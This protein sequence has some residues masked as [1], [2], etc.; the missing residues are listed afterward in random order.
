MGVIVGVNAGEWPSAI[1]HVSNGEPASEVVLRRPSIDL[2]NRTLALKTFTEN[3]ETGR[4]V[5]AGNV[6]DGSPGSS[7]LGGLID[8]FN[9]THTHAG[10]GIS[11][12]LDWQAGYDNDALTGP[13]EAAVTLDAGGSFSIQ[14]SDT[15]DLLKF[16]ETTQE[17]SA[18]VPVFTKSVFKFG[19][20]AGELNA[21]LIPNGTT[22]VLLDNTEVTSY[23]DH[24]TATMSNPH[25]HKYHGYPVN[26]TNVIVTGGSHIVTTEMSG[27]DPGGADGV[28]GIVT[29]PAHNNVI[30]RNVD[31]NDLLDGTGNKVYGRITESGGVWTLSFYSNVAGSEVAHNGFSSQEIQWW[32]QKI[33][34]PQDRPVYNPLFELPANQLAAVV[35]WE[36]VPTDIIPAGAYTLGESGN[37]WENFHLEKFKEVSF[38]TGTNI[39]NHLDGIAFTNA[40][41]RFESAFLPLPA[42][43]TNPVPFRPQIPQNIIVGSGPEAH[44]A[45]IE[46]AIANAVDGDTIYVTEDAFSTESM[47]WTSS[48]QRIRVV[49]LPGVIYEFNIAS[50][51]GYTSYININM[52]NATID[53]LT[54]HIS[55][56]RPNMLQAIFFNGSNSR[57]INARVRLLSSSN[58]DYGVTLANSTGGQH[59]RMIIRRTP[60]I[61]GSIASGSFRELNTSGFNS[62]VVQL[63]ET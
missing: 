26:K 38:G 7:V 45:T 41:Q 51:P 59:L 62:A 61:S 22:N 5:Q 10:D 46:D 18:G 23:D 30:I 19:T 16:D 1:Q 54:V 58:L 63:A 8:A 13:R 31:Y 49:F 9:T 11:A 44:Y 42:V 50:G 2:E 40:G 56:S 52:P 35:D 25:G 17:I 12:K 34:S 57:L 15:T 14:A 20:S 55:S 60:G 53:G 37:A 21:N 3:E 32:V 33:F 48:G 36:N 24:V 27:E 6:N 47:V 39:V 43:N 28:T 4:D 29:D